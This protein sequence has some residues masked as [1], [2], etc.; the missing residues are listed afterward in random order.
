MLSLTK[1]FVCQKNG[2]E[3]FIDH[4]PFLHFLIDALPSNDARAHYVLDFHVISEKT[5]LNVSVFLSLRHQNALFHWI[6]FGF[7]VVNFYLQYVL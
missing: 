5:E 2:A 6:H 4:P 7:L 3:C 1:L